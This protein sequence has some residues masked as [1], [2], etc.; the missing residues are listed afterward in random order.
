[1]TLEA[2]IQQG[3]HDAIVEMFDIDLSPIT[4]D[5]ADI[6]YFTNQLKEDGTKVQWKGNIY[7]PLPILAAGYDR[8]TNGQVA[9]PSLTVANVLGTFSQV[10][11]SFDDLVGGKVTRRRTLQKYLDG[12]PQADTLQEFPIDIFYIERKTQETA[13]AITWQLSSI[14]DLEGVRLPRRV[15]TQNLCLWKYRSSECGYTGAPVFNSRDQI[16]STNGQSTEAVTAINAWYLREQR[17]TELRTATEFR[18]QAAGNKEAACASYVLLESRYTYPFPANYVISF[19]SGDGDPF[20]GYWDSVAVTL[21]L[22]YRQ[23]PQISSSNI[24]LAAAFNK[25]YRIERWG[26]DAAGC[27]TAT[28]ALASAEAALTT[29]QNNL[30]SAEAALSAAIAALPT[31]DALRLEDICGKRV[32]SC[33]LRFPEQSLPF[34]GFPG[35]NLT[36]S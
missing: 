6:Y 1:M 10:V 30:S 25:F 32:S 34:G 8:N 19:S 11:K 14:L 13:I 18:N 36:R 28:N 17:K 2:D 29:A 35:A 22:E 26:P 3:W 21:G 9:Q 33:T 23:G 16:I 27:T 20:I 4:N 12:S 5:P 7:E 24:F 31:D 15:I